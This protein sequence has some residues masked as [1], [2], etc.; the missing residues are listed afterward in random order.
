MGQEG[1]GHLEKCWFSFWIPVLTK[2]HVHCHSHT[3]ASL[4][5]NTM[6]MNHTEKTVHAIMTDTIKHLKF[7]VQLPS[8]FEELKDEGEPTRDASLPRALFRPFHWCGLNLPLSSWVHFGTETRD[9]SPGKI[10]R[11][12]ISSQDIPALW[13]IRWSTKIISN[14]NTVSLG[15]VLPTTLH[16]HTQL[17]MVVKIF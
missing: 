7:S 1:D 3:K 17:P 15:H 14:E 5:D 9:T 8:Y 11:Y 6:C 2:H 10:P 16:I 12:L 4:C 13:V